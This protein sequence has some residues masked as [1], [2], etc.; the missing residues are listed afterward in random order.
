MTDNFVGA[1]YETLMMSNDDGDMGPFLPQ[2]EAKSFIHLDASL[3]APTLIG[4]TQGVGKTDVGTW[5]RELPGRNVFLG[6]RSQ[7]ATAEDLR[8]RTSKSVKEWS[9][10]NA[11]VCTGFAPGSYT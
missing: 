2:N 8:D 5:E 6:L 11:A 9:G 4:G 1:M 7:L 10:S 3:T